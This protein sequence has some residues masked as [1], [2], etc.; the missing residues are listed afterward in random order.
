MKRY[1]LNKVNTSHQLSDEE[2]IRYKN[3][4]RLHHQYDKITKRPAK[5]LYKNPIAF[6]I[7][8]LIILLALLLSGEI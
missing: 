3:F 8:V 2:I 7:L 5:P 4:S 1:K 6:F